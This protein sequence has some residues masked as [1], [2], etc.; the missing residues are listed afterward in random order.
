MLN[1]IHFFNDLIVLF[2]SFLCWPLLSSL[3]HQ[4]LDRRALSKV[5]ERYWEDESSTIQFEQLFVTYECRDSWCPLEN[6]LKVTGNDI[7]Y[8]TT[9][10]T[11]NCP[12]DDT[13]AERASD[14]ATLYRHVSITNLATLPQTI[15]LSLPNAAESSTNTVEDCT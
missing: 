11:K 7:S 2:D 12:N 4:F 9:I 6:H 13:V 8:Q 5:P 15:S 1:L 14:L 10:W 3:L